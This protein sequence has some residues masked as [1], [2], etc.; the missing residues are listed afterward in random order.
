MCCQIFSLKPLPTPGTL[1]GKQRN[2]LKRALL[3]SPAGEK[4]LTV[5]RLLWKGSSKNISTPILHTHL[6]LGHLPPWSPQI[7]RKGG[8]GSSWLAQPTAYTA[9]ECLVTS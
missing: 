7:T 4:V 9:Q 5:G 3:Y 6:G 1:S 8:H 2:L